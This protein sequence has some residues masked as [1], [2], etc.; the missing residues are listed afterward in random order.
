M[1]G[2]HTY[3]SEFCTFYPIGFC[4]ERQVLVE[5][6]FLNP[7]F[8]IHPL[9]P[10]TTPFDV[11]FNRQAEMNNNHGSVGVGFGT[12]VQRHTETPYK[13]Y[14]Q[15]L[16]HPDIFEFKLQQIEYYYKQRGLTVGPTK[17]FFDSYMEAVREIQESDYIQIAPINKIVHAYNN[18]VFE[19]AQGIMLDQDFGFF[20]HVTRSN[21][22][23]KNALEIMSQCN[24]A[25]PEIYYIMRSYLTR[26]GNGYMPGE[27]EITLKNA[28]METNVQHDWQGKFRKGYHSYRLL[29]YALDCDELQHKQLN[30]ARNFVVSCLDQTDGKIL[31]DDK[32]VEL[33]EFLNHNLFSKANLI[34]TS[35]GGVTLKEYKSNAKTAAAE[36]EDI[37]QYFVF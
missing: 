8:F 37:A 21:T 2:A 17:D 6:G 35:E 34:L 31:V 29:S 13:L 5:K 16:K 25:D 33:K 28:E 24:L 27:T 14:A 22:T 30:P 32:A 10:I 9:S 4:K 7:V 12:T 11:A 20:P 36:L 23:C 3:W 15:D 26:H 19:G 1:N 18:F